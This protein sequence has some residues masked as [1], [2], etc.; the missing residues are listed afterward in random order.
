MKS[1][2]NTRSHAHF[3]YHYSILALVILIGAGLRLYKLTSQSLWYDELMTMAISMKSHSFNEWLNITASDR[4]P[5]L[6]YF[7]VNHWG[8][9]FHYSEYSVRLL[10]ALIGIAGLISIYFLG[11]IYYDRNTGLY[12]A[13]ITT[14]STYHLYYSQEVRA[15]I[16]VFLLSTIF[17]IFFLKAYREPTW[18]NLAGVTLFSSLNIYTHFVAIFFMAA[19][20]CTAP[21]VAYAD[22]KRG[23]F[24]KGFSLATLGVIILTLPLIGPLRRAAAEKSFSPN[25]KVPEE[26]L[27][28]AVVQLL[29][30]KFSVALF[31]L[32]LVFLLVLMLKSSHNALKPA[33][34][35]KHLLPPTALILYVIL[36]GLLGIYLKSRLSSPMISPRY[37]VFCLPLMMI[38]MGMMLAI[39]KPV[40]IR[41]LILVIIA[42]GFFQ[43]IINE[44]NFYTEIRKDQ[45]R[46]TSRYIVDYS[47][48]LKE[49]GVDSQVVFS[50]IASQLNYYVKNRL[51][52]LH[53]SNKALDVIIK[54]NKSNQIL[55]LWQV[56]YGSWNEPSD[57]WF[58]KAMVFYGFHHTT[59][60]DFKNVVV[61]FY[62]NNPIPVSFD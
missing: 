36:V 48:K 7:L 18:K 3:Y 23:K 31:G 38:F 17:L 41:Y 22:N 15:Y 45:L 55:G 32:S 47:W 26:I 53:Y 14:F 61:K 54:K 49:N 43:K 37:F 6:F 46:E 5:P 56:Q 10:A 12:A 21:I 40:W 16:L 9:H 51:P 4:N 57:K 52:L 28:Y 50:G 2:P 30:D 19:I 59:R 27:S 33:T 25:I 35:F 34:E 8:A 62:S 58:E 20:I 24:I 11:K 13:F 60:K 39:L 1:S 44:K 42:V 29:N